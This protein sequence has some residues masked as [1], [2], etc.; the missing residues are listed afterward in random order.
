MKLGALMNL[1]LRLLFLSFAE[2]VKLAQREVQL[3]VWVAKPGLASRLL[4]PWKSGLAQTMVAHLQRASVTASWA[5]RLAALLVCEQLH[6]SLVEQLLERTCRV[7]WKVA[8][9]LQSHDSPDGP[10]FGFL[11][12]TPGIEKL[13]GL[14][15]ALLGLFVVAAVVESVAQAASELSPEHSDFEKADLEQL[16]CL[17]ST[18]WEGVAVGAR[19]LWIASWALLGAES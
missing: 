6:P 1:V 15:V 2:K 19:R 8:S 10:L 11:Q 5:E 17:N 4:L 14:M 3:Y 16:R 12:Q 18:S 7:E 13:Q 9:R